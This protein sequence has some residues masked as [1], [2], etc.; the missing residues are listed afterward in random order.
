MKYNPSDEVLREIAKK[1][2]WVRW[3][4]KFLRKESCCPHEAFN[5]SSRVT[6]PGEKSLCFRIFKVD[7][8]RDRCPCC[9][10]FIGESKVNEVVKKIIQFSREE[11]HEI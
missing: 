6:C 9:S 4:K 1:K 11:Q 3:C 5:L 8:T 2:K 10:M 7:Y